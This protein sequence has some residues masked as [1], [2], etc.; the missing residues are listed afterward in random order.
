M[1]LHR[2]Q[3]RQY[4]NIISQLGKAFFKSYAL[5]VFLTFYC[6]DFEGIYNIVCFECAANYG[7][8][9]CDFFLAF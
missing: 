5:H 3:F 1:K 6:S 8:T 9:G 4:V 7:V 2:R